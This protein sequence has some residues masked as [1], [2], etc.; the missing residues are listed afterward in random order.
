MYPKF[1]K[2]TATPETMST[3]TAERAKEAVISHH[4]DSYATW[5]NNV[6]SKGTT[7]PRLRCS[8][9]PHAPTSLDW[10]GSRTRGGTLLA[11]SGCSLP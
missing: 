2:K 4:D 11:G 3:C 5:V 10:V 8:S 1:T 7:G 9:S 6:P